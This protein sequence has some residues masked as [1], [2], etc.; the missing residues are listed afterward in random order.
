MSVTKIDMFLKPEG[1][2]Y[3]SK[4]LN[5]LKGKIAELDKTEQIE[6][7]KIIKNNNDRLTENK[8]GV[9]INL[10]NVSNKC[11]EDI[12]NFVRYSVENK[13]R[14]DNLEKLSQNIFKES[15][16]KQHYDNYAFHGETDKSDQ[17]TGDSKE[18]TKE[19]TKGNT[20]GHSNRDKMNHTNLGENKDSIFAENINDNTDLN[21]EN[22]VS[23]MGNLKDD[24]EDD[25]EEDDLDVDDLKTMLSGP[26]HLRSKNNNKDDH[27]LDDRENPLDEEDLD[28][29]EI[30]DGD[31]EIPVKLIPIAQSNFS[32]FSQEINF[33]KNKLS[34][35]TARIL[36]KCKELNRNHYQDNTISSVTYESGVNG[37]EVSDD[38]DD[39]DNGYSSLIVKKNY[40][41]LTSE[42]TEETII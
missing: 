25:D 6:I 15:M 19:D 2:D 22:D 13:T 23:L 17:L 33:K 1:K 42:L 9:F 16:L 31:G 12:D 24:D 41:E 11:L 20:K 27:D 3:S 30:D 7:L 36:K 32:E 26:P 37:N 40:Q 21:S 34:G 14:L 18:D 10:T 35:R 39:E 29:P 38:E 28:N 5:V 8:N 4:E